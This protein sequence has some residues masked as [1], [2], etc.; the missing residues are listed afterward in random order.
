VLG[1]GATWQWRRP[2]ASGPR[3]Y[4]LAAFAGYWFLTTPIGA[5]LLVGGLS[6]G[7]TRITTREQA[8]QA[9][10]VVV[11]G[12]GTS[13]VMVGHETGGALTL[14]SLLRSLEGARVFKLI[15]ARILIVSGGI[16]RPD[17][18]LQPECELMRDVV[19]RDGVPPAAVV[20]E[21]HSMNTRDQARA[22]G[23]ILRRYG[24]RRF[25]LVTSP[26][27]MRRSVAVFRAAG[28]D[29][30]ASVAP[31]R[32]EYLPPPP[33]LLPNDDSFAL[34]DAA[35]YDYVALVYYWSR[36]WLR[37]SPAQVPAP[38]RVSLMPLTPG[39]P[40]ATKPR[41]APPDDALTQ[42]AYRRPAVR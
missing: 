42:N 34:S 24:S 8:D 6:R 20:E 19:V 12:G 38:S 33:W 15:G 1:I 37:P 32:S 2:A 5:G 7:L 17:R 28:L 11:L 35:V 40:A 26:M 21:S 18:Q 3:W 27:H 25:V 23:P 29:P 31:V 10:A 22:I 9:D 4:L 41:L 30:L 39:L 14:A 36:G 16:A 13:T